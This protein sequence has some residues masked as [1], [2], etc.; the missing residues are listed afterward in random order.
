MKLTQV[1]LQA[2]TACKRRHRASEGTVTG[3]ARTVLSSQRAVVRN[4]VVRR[5][6]LMCQ[7]TS[8]IYERLITAVEIASVRKSR[9]MR[10]QW[11]A[12]ILLLWHDAERCHPMPRQIQASR[13]ASMAGMNAMQVV[14]KGSAAHKRQPRAALCSVAGGVGALISRQRTEVHK[15]VVRRAL[16]VC[17]ETS[18]LSE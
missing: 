13:C 2:P 11:H 17:Q 1:I 3:S 9:H 8:G 12:Y 15:C 14:S 7:E 4:R 6:L 10:G 5:A 18:G 16:L